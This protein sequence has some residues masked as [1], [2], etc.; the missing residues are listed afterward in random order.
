MRNVISLEEYKKKRQKMEA[1]NTSWCVSEVIC[2]FCGKRAIAAYPENS[3]LKDW[4]CD[5]CHKKGGIILT[6]QNLFD[7]EEDDLEA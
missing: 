3:F 4:E 6:G 7:D 2:I 5:K 1:E